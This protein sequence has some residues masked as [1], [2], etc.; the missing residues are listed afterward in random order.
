[1]IV[2]LVRD[3]FLNT[4]SAHLPQLVHY[5]PESVNEEIG[6]FWAGP[7]GPDAGNVSTIAVENGRYNYRPRNILSG[8]FLLSRCMTQPRGSLPR[9]P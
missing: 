5:E 9:E 4:I 1:M 8:V 2:H 7:S 3:S 6:A